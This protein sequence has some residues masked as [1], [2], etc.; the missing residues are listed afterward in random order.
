ME[1]LEQLPGGQFGPLKDNLIRKF[2]ARREKIESVFVE[3]ESR[4][5]Q[6]NQ[7]LEIAGKTLVLNVYSCSNDASPISE[8]DKQALLR[9]MGALKIASFPSC[10]VSAAEYERKLVGLT[11][12]LN[13]LGA[14]FRE[15]RAANLE[16]IQSSEQLCKF[17]IPVLQR[18]ADT[19]ADVE[20]RLKEENSSLE[21]NTD[22][23][24]QIQNWY[25][26]F[27]FEKLPEFGKLRNDLVRWSKDWEAEL[28]RA[29]EVYN[30]TLRD[31]ETTKEQVGKLVTFRGFIDCSG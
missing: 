6:N 22:C 2:D 9:E 5:G 19:A 4:R 24:I 7:L 10:A 13:E 27:K 20:A 16:N 14:R 29:Q 1:A 25:E 12:R 21:G 3:L 26:A 23:S 17:D 31:A 8:E 15:V 11:G 28:T 30:L 18:F